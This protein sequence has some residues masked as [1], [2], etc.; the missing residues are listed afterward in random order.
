M[1]EKKNRSV[2]EPE[3]GEFVISRVFDAPREIVFK[4]HAES[5]RLERWW[6]AKGFM[7]RVI[8]LDF[9]PGGVFHYSMR[10]PDG[11]EMWGKFVYC[12][13]IA[14]ERIV[15][16]NSFVDVDKNGNTI[17]APFS[18]TWPLEV[19]NTL[20]LSE[21]KGKTTLT[22]RSVPFNA[23]KEERE[24]FEAGLDSLRQGFNGSLY[25]L[26]DYLAQG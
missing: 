1:A 8:K 19:L 20:T 6:G 15:F 26:A 9:R 13:I 21:H 5:E 22:I 11:H 25:Q 2:T 16:T 17:R 7:T 4:A 18:S 10:T 14:P 24:T 23:I 12:E 3:K